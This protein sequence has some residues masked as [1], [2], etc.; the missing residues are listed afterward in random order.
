MRVENTEQEA[1]EESRGGLE[2][3]LT[4][5]FLACV[6]LEKTYFLGAPVQVYSICCF[7]L[8]FLFVFSFL[9]LLQGGRKV[10]IYIRI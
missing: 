9:F 2:Q 7:F 10:G 5:I 1:H 6:L 8:F 4:S 3:S